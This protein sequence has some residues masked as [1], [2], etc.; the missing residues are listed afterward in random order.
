MKSK[1]TT[2]ENQG[3]DA[4]KM[5]VVVEKDEWFVRNEK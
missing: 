2:N 1:K 3:T 5:E 4:T